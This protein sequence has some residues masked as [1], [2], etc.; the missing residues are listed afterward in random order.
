MASPQKE[1]GYTAIANAIMEAL[2]K[3]RIPGELRQVL[4]YILRRTY[5]WN[6]KES[7]IAH[8]EFILATGLK[9]QNVSRALKRLSDFNMIGIKIDASGRRFYRFN[10]DFDTWSRGIKTDA[11][12]R[13]IHSGI[14]TDASGESELMPFMPS[15]TNNGKGLRPPKAIFKANINQSLYRERLLKKLKALFPDTKIP[16]YVT[17]KQIDYFLFRVEGGLDHRR[18][19]DPVRYLKS[20]IVEEDF[21]P[22]LAR[23]EKAKEE[24]RQRVEKLRKEQEVRE[25]FRQE[26]HEEMQKEIKAFVSKIAGKGMD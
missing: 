22:L 18:V 26:N 13:M 20:L 9:R 1:H 2:A 5:G 12:S 15:G 25:A 21:P 7:A 11:A 3:V 8:R 24:E 19:Q 4:D 10:K 6:K 16:G 14:K 23:E 17:N